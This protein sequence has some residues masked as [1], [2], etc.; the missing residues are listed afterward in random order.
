MEEPPQESG[1]NL[2]NN[3]P[4]VCSNSTTRLCFG[5]I[6]RGLSNLRSF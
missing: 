1:S 6:K 2:R 4:T 3:L 5:R